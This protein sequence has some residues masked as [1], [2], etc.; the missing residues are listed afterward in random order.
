MVQKNG[1]VVWCK[2]TTFR[3]WFGK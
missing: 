1:K 3:L 2:I